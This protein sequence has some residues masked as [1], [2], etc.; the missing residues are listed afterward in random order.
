MSNDSFLGGQADSAAHIILVFEGI[1]TML[2]VDIA[3]TII[4]GLLPPSLE[5][6]CRAPFIKD[7][8]G[9]V[10]CMVSNLP[11]RIFIIEVTLGRAGHAWTDCL[12]VPLGKN[13]VLKSTAG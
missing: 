11:G 7:N 12:S 6:F 3:P 1:I 13:N 10:A 5:W 4:G 9:S 8:K 2:T